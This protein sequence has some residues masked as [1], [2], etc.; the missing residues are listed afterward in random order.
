MTRNPNPFVLS[1]PNML[2]PT[3][4]LDSKTSNDNGRLLAGASPS[5]SCSTG[6]GACYT[7]ATRTLTLGNNDS[8]TL[9]GGVY[10]FCQINLG[11]NSSINIAAGA[12]MLIYIDSPGR[13]GS[14][15][16]AGTGGISTGNGATFSNPSQDPTR[17]GDRDLRQA[18]AWPTIEFPNNLTVYAAIYAPN[19]GIQFKN[20]GNLVGGLTAQSIEFKNN[21]FLWDDRVSTIHLATTLRLLP[22]RLAQ[23][24]C[25]VSSTT[26]PRDRLPVGRRRRRR[27]G[28]HRKRR[29]ARHSRR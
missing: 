2:N 3:T 4:L 29:S 14:G 11:N 18:P 28:R 20:N 10:N 16:P 25:R 26:A 15:C 1:P 21:A 8:V 6:S 22:R 23:C 7:A 19:T 17:A 9:G 12:K 5:D 27:A 13:S 24:N